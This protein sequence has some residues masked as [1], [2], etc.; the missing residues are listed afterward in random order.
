MLS[1]V[2]LFVAP[3]TVAHQASLS[4]TISQSLLKLTFIES[5]LI[6]VTKHCLVGQTRLT[7]IFLRRLQLSHY[8]Q[9]VLLERAHRGPHAIL[10]GTGFRNQAHL[11]LAP[12]TYRRRP[13]Y[14]DLSPAV[15]NVCRVQTWSHPQYTPLLRSQPVSGTD[16]QANICHHGG[17]PVPLQNQ[18]CD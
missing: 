3:W 16:Q 2:Q 18:T 14:S 11:P 9:A 8:S 13:A 12:L 5:D 1:C 17:I 7:A 10:P 6:E 4:F 15:R